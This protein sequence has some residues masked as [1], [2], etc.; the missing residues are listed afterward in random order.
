LAAPL[1]N[2]A[3]FLR[4]DFAGIEMIQPLF[5]RYIDRVLLNTALDMASRF[6]G[7]LPAPRI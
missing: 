5:M 4:A 6:S 1:R 2:L 3:V 7:C